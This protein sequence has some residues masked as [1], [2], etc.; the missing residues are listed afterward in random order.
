MRT[1]GATGLP[2][3]PLGLGLAALGRPGYINLGHAADLGDDRRG[4]M[5]HRAHAVLDAAYEAGVRYF[6]AARSYGRAEEF[7]ARGCAPRVAPGDGDGRLEVGL[8]LHR[9]LAGRRRRARG[10]GPL[11]RRRCAA[12][13]RDAR[14]AR[15]APGALPDPL[16]DARE[17]RAR[18]PRGARRARRACASERRARSGSPSPAPR[19]AETIER[20]LEVGGFDTVQ[21][22]WN[23]LERSAGPALAEAHDAGLGVIVKEALAN[24]RLT[25]RGDAGGRWPRAAR[26]RGDDAGRAR[27][28]RR[29][30]PALGRRRAQ[31][32]G[33]RR[34]LA[35][36]C[37]ALDVAWDAELDE[38]LAAWPSPRR[39]LGGA[40]G[41]RPGRSRRGHCA[42]P[43]TTAVAF[44]PSKRKPLPEATTTQRIPARRDWQRKRP[45]VRARP[46][47]S[48]GPPMP[49]GS[50]LR[51]VTADP[52]VDAQLYVRGLSAPEP[53]P[54]VDPR[55]VRWSRRR[56]C[57][58]RRG[59][60]T[61][62]NTTACLTSQGWPGR[63][64]AP[65]PGHARR[66]R[67]S[68]RRARA[69]PG[70]GRSASRPGGRRGLSTWRSPPTATSGEDRNSYGTLKTS[71]QALPVEPVDRP[72]LR[73]PTRGRRE[74]DGH[75]LAAGPC[76]RAA[77]RPG[78]AGRSRSA[79]R[80]C[81]PG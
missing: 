45:A 57:G 70:R 64:L 27:A 40:L 71:S 25:A 21:A 44:L 75:R 19:Q 58:R 80:G 52:A 53:D 39:V 3:S 26:E 12:S 11:G 17:R 9:R 73:R 8:H 78:R 51:T 66:G 30:G 81:R 67:P 56:S 48:D 6:D 41:A 63:D 59:R 42:R 50:G 60:E 65:G 24:G 77:Q 72:A 76:E 14:A 10:Q 5:E 2:V 18:R 54:A 4:G 61:W 7:L 68:A 29:A 13:G 38:A 46:K 69:R 28:G 47:A 32:R 23:L 33:D 20:A 16:G 35:A 1:L 62:A 49:C 22:T 34:P 74:G 31:R 55:P 37:A 79:P 43:G 36:T 15:R